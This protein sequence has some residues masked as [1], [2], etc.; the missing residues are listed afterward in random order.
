MTAP[1]TLVS[2]HRSCR[3]RTNRFM[4][5]FLLAGGPSAR[6]C[7]YGS[8]EAQRIALQGSAGV[9]CRPPHHAVRLPWWRS[10]DDLDADACCE[11]INSAR[12]EMDGLNGAALAFVAIPI[13][14]ETGTPPSPP[15]A[16]HG[17]SFSSNNARP[18]LS[19]ERYVVGNERNVLLLRLRNEDAIER[20]AMLPHKGPRSRGTL[21][22]QT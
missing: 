16:P 7:T 18:L 14:T 19:S 2:K 22:I 13:S 11:V 17:A 15:R 9:H 10:Y 8:P 1:G 12:C 5:G 4:P 3:T 6:P 20:I 21:E